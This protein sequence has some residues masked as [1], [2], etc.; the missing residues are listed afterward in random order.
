[1]K[2]ILRIKSA[3]FLYSCDLPA[4][5]NILRRND[6]ARVDD[7]STGDVIFYTYS[8]NVGFVNDLD[9]LYGLSPALNF[10]S[11]Q[12]PV[13]YGDEIPLADYKFCLNRVHYWQSAS[14]YYKPCVFA[15]WRLARNLSRKLSKQ[16]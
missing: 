2:E 9:D 16:I 7:V 14:I 5:K 15:W 10:L 1:M 12:R 4:V 13:V 3:D 11:P 8:R 6:I